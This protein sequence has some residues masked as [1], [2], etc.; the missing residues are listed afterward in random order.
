MSAKIRTETVRLRHRA[1][2]PET[3][4]LTWYR[5]T[6]DLPMTCGAVLNEFGH[7]LSHRDN[8]WVA[9]GTDG[10]YYEVNPPVFWCYIPTAP[11]L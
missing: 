10:G 1:E 4:T 9:L 11:H 8:R 2:E 5:T 7:K 3:V 6:E